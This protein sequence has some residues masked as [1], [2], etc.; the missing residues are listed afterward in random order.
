LVVTINNGSNTNNSSY[1]NARHT[2]NS[3]PKRLQKRFVRKQKVVVIFHNF[4]S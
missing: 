4:S 1:A 3:V 2:E